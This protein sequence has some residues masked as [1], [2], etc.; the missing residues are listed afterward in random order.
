MDT[1][2]FSSSEKESLQRL[3]VTAVILFGSQARGLAG[4]ASDYDVG[5]IRDAY[6][7]RKDNG[8]MYDRLYEL[9]SPKIGKLV[10]ID[11]VFLDAAPLELAHHA[12]KYGLVLYEQPPG[13][14]ARFKEFVMERYADFAPYRQMF[15]AQILRRIPS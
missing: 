6:A 15:Q 8:A 4:E 14:F 3:G 13:S 2:T 7:I 9:L 5:V 1:I 12:A 11:I 10:N